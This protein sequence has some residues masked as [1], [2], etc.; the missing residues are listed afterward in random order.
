MIW[1]VHWLA[2]HTGTINEGGPYYGFFSG[3]GSDLSE[4]AILGGLIAVVRRHNCEVHHCWRLGRHQ[5]AAGHHVCRAH[6]PDDHLT[7]EA[8][9]RTGDDTADPG[10]EAQVLGKL[11]GL[12]ERIADLAEA[13]ATVMAARTAKAPAEKTLAKPAAK[14]TP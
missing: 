4:I 2:V 11:D 8:A 13:V 5:T 6:H 3:F 10:Q 7:A 9:L 12:D 1:L 14:R